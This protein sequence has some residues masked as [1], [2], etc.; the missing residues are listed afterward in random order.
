MGTLKKVNFRK[1]NW[2]LAARIRDE[3]AGSRRERRSSDLRPPAR[4]S[5]LAHAP[6]KKY[7]SPDS[8]HQTTSSPTSYQSSHTTLLVHTTNIA[9]RH[10]TRT[11]SWF[12]CSSTR[13]AARTHTHSNPKE[14]A[15]IARIK[16]ASRIVNL[17]STCHSENL[18]PSR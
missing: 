2:P 5:V 7:P 16:S 4:R 9:S 6:W 17:D 8:S 18:S 14:P 12:A 15:D 11:F 10:R 13:Q 1:K 3:S